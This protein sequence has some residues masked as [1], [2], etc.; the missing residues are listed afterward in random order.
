MGLEHLGVLLLLWLL[1]VV[2]DCFRYHY[3]LEKTNRKPFHGFVIFI[4]MLV[5]CIHL[6]LFDVK[7]L[8]EYIPIITYQGCAYILVFSPLLSISRKKEFWYLSRDHGLLNRVLLKNN[9]AFYF[10][11]YFGAMV[12]IYLSLLILCIKH[13]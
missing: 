13:L 9:I 6:S 7:A 4:R 10:V 8:L 2:V 1:I 3:L 12:L 5:G 11:L